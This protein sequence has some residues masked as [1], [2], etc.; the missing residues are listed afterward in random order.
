[1]GASNLPVQ[2]L[3]FLI[4]TVYYCLAVYN[5]FACH[6]FFLLQ[7]LSVGIKWCISVG[8]DKNTSLPL[9]EIE[10]FSLSAAFSQ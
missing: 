2:F 1:M 8:V 6:F 3:I 7:Q 4:V 5:N 10:N 9:P